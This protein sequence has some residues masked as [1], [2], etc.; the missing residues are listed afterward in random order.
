[1]SKGFSATINQAANA[2]RNTSNE[3]HQTGSQQATETTKKRAATGALTTASDSLKKK[4]AAGAAK[5]STVQ[6]AA[7]EL[8]VKDAVLDGRSDARNAELAYAVGYLDEAANAR[9]EVTLQ[10]Q[11]GKKKIA[12]STDAELIEFI[13]AEIDESDVEE[14]M[15]KLLACSGKNGENTRSLNLLEGVF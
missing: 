1:M 3:G 13:E 6:K 11:A 14:S 15:G 7:K 4:A 9:T 12:D 8:Q 2:V 5:L 10:L